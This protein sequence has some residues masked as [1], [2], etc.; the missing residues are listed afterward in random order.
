MAIELI[1]YLLMIICTINDIAVTGLDEVYR[2][3]DY[4][5]IGTKGAYNSKNRRLSN[6]L[7]CFWKRAIK[8]SNK[9]LDKAK[10]IWGWRGDN[11]EYRD[12][13]ERLLADSKNYVQEDEIFYRIKQYREIIVAELIKQRVFTTA[14][15]LKEKKLNDDLNRPDSKALCTVRA[16]ATLIS[17]SNVIWFLAH[18]ALHI[19]SNL[20]KHG[21]GNTAVLRALN[22]ILKDEECIYENFCMFMLQTS[23]GYSVNNEVI[24]MV[25]KHT[26][27]L[28]TLLEAVEEKAKWLIV[29]GA[30][31]K[32]DYE[33]A[34]T[35][36]SMWRN[37]G[38]KIDESEYDDEYDSPEFYKISRYIDAKMIAQ[39]ILAA[40]DMEKLNYSNFPN[41][42]SDLDKW[43]VDIS[44]FFD[45]EEYKNEALTYLI[46]EAAIASAKVDSSWPLAKMPDNM[47]MDPEKYFNECIITAAIALEKEHDSKNPGMYNNCC[48]IK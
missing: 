2:A 4:I 33:K 17:Y 28:A 27:D 16:I 32:A 42:I 23:T 12:S 31:E 3:I 19:I 24:K 9:L 34:V 47:T 40:E 37:N 46:G 29:K 5:E 1:T 11:T 14:S 35:A 25:S 48:N 41:F 20:E 10:Y 39:M 38:E 13:I 18:Q 36:M 43:G 8:N 22:N 26:Q 30:E 7:R 21:I 15:S 45:S 6:N 44:Q